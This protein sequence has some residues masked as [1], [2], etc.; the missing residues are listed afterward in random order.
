M[1][2]DEK[3]NNILDQCLER[4]LNKGGTVEQCLADY[5]EQATELEP[6]LQMALMVKKASAIQPHPEFAARAR[7]QFRSA[8]QTA[9]PKRRF[10]FFGWQSRWAT[11]VAV[12]LILLLA[13]SGTVVAADNSM[14]DSPLYPVKLVTEQ[15]RVRLTPSDIGKAELY[16][17]LADRRVAEIAHMAGKGKSER[18]E[19]LTQRLDTLLVR[20]AVL[21]AVEGEE[22]GAVLAPAPTPA[23]APLPGAEEKTAERVP[24]QDT[25]RGRLR[26]SL[27]RY[28]ADNPAKLRAVLENAPES[29]RPALR[30]AIEVSL[31]RYQQALKALE[32]ID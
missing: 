27:V 14:P 2:K 19:W 9:K 32:E 16:A 23:P 20:V 4:I 11:V 21:V 30:Q 29:A 5:P 8:L 18:V 24:R 7:Y 22:G 6:L 12:V 3:F 1:K 26:M 15:V 25:R 31:R 28:A 10:S 17:K 13:G